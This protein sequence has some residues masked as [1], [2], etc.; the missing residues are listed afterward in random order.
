ME[1]D[2]PSKTIEWP[3][4]GA[5]GAKKIQLFIF[6]PFVPFCGHLMKLMLRRRP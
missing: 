5:K 1:N 4:K 2:F 3:Q 6:A